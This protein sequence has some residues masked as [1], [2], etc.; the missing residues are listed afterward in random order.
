MREVYVG[1]LWLGIGCAGAGFWI[2]ANRLLPLWAI[3][4]LA[5]LGAVLWVLAEYLERRE[6]KNNDAG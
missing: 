2:G 4:A 3:V 1:R 6:D 5:V